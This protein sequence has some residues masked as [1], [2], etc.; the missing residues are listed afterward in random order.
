MDNE[1]RDYW[2]PFHRFFI[3]LPT[4]LVALVVWYVMS[5]SEREK[6]RLEYVR[7]AASILQREANEVDSQREMR[8][9]A[10]A[11][12]NK[13]APVKLSVEQANALIEGTA[14]LPRSAY[15]DDQGFDWGG[16]E[17]GPSPD[18]ALR[19]LRA[20]SPSPNPSPQ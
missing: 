6:I 2:T 11:V 10:V 7:I 9:W 20:Y 4:V 3:V 19:E 5:G 12:L 16:Y 14:R 8:E 18:E 15:L 13:S 17:G 1:K